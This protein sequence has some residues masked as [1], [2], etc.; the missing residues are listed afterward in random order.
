MARLYG[1]T[2]TRAELTRRVGDLDQVAGVTLYEH[3]DGPAR[4]VRS[5][6]FRTGSGLL[7]DVL[8]DRGMDIGMAEWRGQP[9]AWRSPTGNVAPAFYEGSGL[10]WLRSFHGGLVATCGLQNVGAPVDD[11]GEH[12][13]LHGR[14]DNTPAARVA[15][16]AEWQGDEYLLWCEGQVREARVFG[17]NLRLTR[18]VSTRLGANSLLIEDAVEN[19][20]FTPT[21][22]LILYHI[23]GGWP[24]LDAEAELL[25]D[26][27]TAEAR[28]ADAAAGLPRL[29]RFEAPTAGFREQVY[30]H[31]V[32]PAADGTATVA[33][34]NRAFAGGQGFGLVIRYD[35]R[36][37]PSLWQW[38][39]MGEG[40]YVV[41]IEPG[42]AHWHG[43]AA[44]R[45]AG[46]LRSLEPG[47]TERFRVEIGA[48]PDTAAIDA[49]ARE[50]GSR[51]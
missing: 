39:M 9:L 7:F 44:A 33:L 36:T 45:Q 35:S 42:N 40:A 51:A 26:G 38:K 28:D 1:Q 19:L 20:G 5:L 29:G 48:L 27:V 21:P 23:N 24:L 15:Y 32:R 30:Q 2:W 13:G 43:R 31:R 11:A 12:F 3:A 25:L 22:L 37:L 18:R 4:G 16:G 34:V 17:E 14:I 8:L 47:E 50:I 41:G 46:I 10:G 6:L 49:V